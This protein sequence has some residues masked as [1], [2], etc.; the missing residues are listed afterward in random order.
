VVYYWRSHLKKAGIDE[1]G[2]FSS[3]NRMAD[4][5]DRLACSGRPPWGAPTFPVTNTLHQVASWIWSRGGDFVSE[6]GKRTLFCEPEALEGICEYLKLSRYMPHRFQSLDHILDTFEDRSISAIIDGP[7]FLMRMMLGGASTEILDDLGAAMPPGPPFVGGSDLVVWRH[8]P[9][10]KAAAGLALVKHLTSPKIQR[11]ICE[12]TGLLPVRTAL[13]E[14]A[15]YASNPHFRVFGE[16]LRFGRSLPMIAFWG[17]LEDRLVQA[18]G[19]IWKDVAGHRGCTSD[20]S[21]IL[22]HL[23]PVA[24]RFDRLLRLV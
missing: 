3:P 6:D 1:Q 20:Q 12:T 14:E 13:F 23:E 16:A 18:F 2:A 24:K 11:E 5:L 22:E 10:D 7:W 4:T 21:I 17:P 15:P 9:D 19:A 8:V